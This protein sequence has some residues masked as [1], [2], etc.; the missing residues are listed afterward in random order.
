MKEDVRDAAAR[1]LNLQEF[2]IIMINAEMKKKYKH[3]PK[4]FK[5]KVE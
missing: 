5:L 2:W 1:K 4:T 3:G